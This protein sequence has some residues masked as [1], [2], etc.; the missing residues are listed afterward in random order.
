MLVPRG[1]L[2]KRRASERWAPPAANFSSHPI[3][4]ILRPIWSLG[5]LVGI[6]KA[7]NDRCP[8]R[9]NLAILPQQNIIRI[10]HKNVRKKEKLM[11]HSDKEASYP[12][13]P[14]AG[15]DCAKR[16][17]LIEKQALLLAKT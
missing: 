3:Q 12:G 8:E 1:M 17:H 5:Q 15:E 11:K 4:V 2:T 14:M 10:K 6:P 13:K 7:E 9:E 16:S